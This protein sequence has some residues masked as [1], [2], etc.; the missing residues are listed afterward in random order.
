MLKIKDL[1]IYSL[2]IK[3]VNNILKFQSRIAPFF[4]VNKGYYFWDCCDNGKTWCHSDVKGSD[5]A[6]A[7][8]PLQF[9]RLF[10]NTIS[11]VIRTQEEERGL[12]M[13]A[14]IR[15]MHTPPHSHHFTAITLSL[16]LKCRLIGMIM[17][18]FIVFTYIITRGGRGYWLASKRVKNHFAPW[19]IQTS[20]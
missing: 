20:L 5:I 12:M 7:C 4:V 9:E 10:K 14:R 6:L 15:V 19:F 3:A 18:L 16:N 11:A 8:P 17:N 2:D 13:M 1:K